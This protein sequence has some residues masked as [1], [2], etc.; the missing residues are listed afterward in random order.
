MKSGLVT[1][2]RYGDAMRIFISGGC[3]NGKSYYAQQLAKAQATDSLYYVATMQS[4]DSEDD[5]RIERHRQER[6]GWGFATVEQPCDIENILHECDSGGSFLLDSLTALLSNEMFPADGDMNEHAA[7]KITRGLNRV[8]DEV[9]NIVIVSDYIYSDA[10]IYDALTEQYRRS[11]A[12][13]DREAAKRCDVVLEVA[14]TSLIV[15]KGK[16]V[17]GGV[18]EK[19]L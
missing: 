7:E 5:E 10:M 8:L 6:D 18:D 19:I 1:A 2:L 17:F 3:K 13:L 14:Y 16:E 15:H 11:L 4:A 12:N 9:E